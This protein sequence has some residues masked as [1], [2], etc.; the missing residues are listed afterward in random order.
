VQTDYVVVEL[1]KQV[2]GTGWQLE[3][4]V[5]VKQGGIERVLL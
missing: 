5:R 2:L 4:F 1:A 3:F